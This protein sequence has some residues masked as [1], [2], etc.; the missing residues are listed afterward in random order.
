MVLRLSTSNGAVLISI[1]VSPFTLNSRWIG[2]HRCRSHMKVGKLV[3]AEFF[4][5]GRNIGSYITLLYFILL[6]ETK[7]LLSTR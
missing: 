3:F 7:Q 4:L 5:A 2:P 1:N 6:N